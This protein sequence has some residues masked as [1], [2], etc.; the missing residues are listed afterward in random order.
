MLEFVQKDRELTVCFREW[1]IEESFAIVSTCLSAD[2]PGL[3]I[4]KK[5]RH[6]I[7]QNTLRLIDDHLGESLSTKQL[8]TKLNTSPRIVQY[9]FKENLG[10]TPL[11]YIL[12]RKL[13]AARTTIING[14]PGGRTNV[15]EI[16]ALYNMS[17][18]GRFSMKYKRL[19]G[20]SPSATVKQM[21][22]RHD[23]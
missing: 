8:A 23:E 10:I 19:F 11:Q 16:A 3:R 14:F 1:V 4:R 13:H 9:A 15:S 12:T 5:S 18:F 7:F 20:E 2:E 21:S 17:H 22:S 6:D